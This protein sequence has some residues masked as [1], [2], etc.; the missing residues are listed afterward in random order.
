MKKTINLLLKNHHI[1]EI[2]TALVKTYIK[3]KNIKVKKNKIVLD[4]LKKSD[5][6][7]LLQKITQVLGHATLADIERAF[8]LLIEKDD[9]QVNGAFYTPPYIVNYMIN[10]TVSGDVT[11]CD[12]S[13]GSGAFL[14]EATNKIHEDTGKS[15]TQIIE[16]NIYGSDILEQATRRTK[17]ILS[18]LALSYGEDKNDINFNIFCWD[19][20]IIDWTKKFPKIF[21]KTSL[22]NVFEI[23][24]NDKKNGFDV[25]IGNPP[26]VRI[27]DFDRSTKETIINKWH[28]IATGNF[29]LHFP[30]FIL[31]TRLLKYG[32]KLGYITPN[33][34]FTSL[35][36]KPLRRFLQDRRLISKILDFDS[37]QI[38]ED[39]TTYTCITFIDKKEK[40]DLDYYIIEK[41]DELK[42]KISTQFDQINFSKIKYNTLNYKK[43][44]LLHEKDYENILKIETIG[45]P[46][47]N[48]TNIHVGIATLKDKLYFIDSSIE[49]N[50]FYFKQ[51]D[52]KLF[53]IEKNITRPLH[54]ISWINDEIDLIDNKMRIICPYVIQNGNAL[55]IRETELK[56]KYPKCYDYFLY[57]K[58]TLATR[59]KNRMQYPEWYAYGR[60][61]GLN[62]FGEKLLT[63]TFSNKPN[64]MLDKKIDSLFCNGYG[65]FKKYPDTNLIILQKILNSVI[66]DYFIR[67]TSVDIEGGYQCYQKNFIESF[68]IPALSKKD[69]EY[70]EKENNQSKINE[71]LIKSYNLDKASLEY[72]MGHS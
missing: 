72:L 21:D 52:N 62:K 16:N 7:P 56:T 47:K 42:N 68:T 23:Y 19:S 51:Y 57:I 44:R 67:K 29:N 70:L 10:N 38:F 22:Y 43:W 50:N 25:I 3:N 58:E 26:Y 8:E 64:F 36:A 5:N 46:L 48:I 53:P 27:Q 49:E 32:G 35:A 11:V 13:C 63:R 30:F 59:D 41:K 33:N 54:K 28:K 37:L 18:L 17:I 69:K 55:I 45:Q 6:E 9:R 31:G 20:L 39:A 34:Y 15:I 71:F 12:P 61:Q 14:I 1:D 24:T 4:Y 40:N 65:I 2:E 66:M 60:S